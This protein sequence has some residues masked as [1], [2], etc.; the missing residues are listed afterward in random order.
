M[1][2]GFL[3]LVVGIESFVDL[4]FDVIFFVTALTEKFQKSLVRCL[5]LSSVE[6]IW[7]ILSARLYGI[8]FFM[9]LG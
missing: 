2:V 8:D 3:V 1:V 6:Q 4:C 7:R 5:K 9:W